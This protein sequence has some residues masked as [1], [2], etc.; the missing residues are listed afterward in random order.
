MQLNI[1]QRKLVQSEPNG[2][3]LIKGVAGS[4]KTTV[5]VFRIP[6]L[7]SHYCYEPDDKILLVTYNKT[8]TNYISHVFNKMDDSSKYEY[9]SIFGMD[10][11]KVEIT[12]IDKIVFEYFLEYKKKNRINLKIERETRLLYQY[13]QQCIAEVKKQYPDVSLIEQKYSSFLMDEIAWIKACDYTELEEYMD[14]D[15]LG[16]MSSTQGD[17]PQRIQKRSKTR[18]AIFELMLRYNDLLRRE[19]KID[20]MDMSCFALKQARQNIK[21]KYTHIIIDESQDLTKIQLEFLTRLYNKKDYSSLMFICDTAQTIYSQSWLVKGRTYSSIGFDM[22]G[23]SQSLS[24]N[25]R[26]TTQVAQAAYSLIEND[27]GFFEDE[28]FVKPS[29]IDRQGEYP[30]YRCFYSSDAELE[31][32]GK[33]I[34]NKLKKE[35]RYQDIVLIARTKN[36]LQE[37][38][39]RLSSMDIP[40]EMMGKDI[41]FEKD[42][43]K[44]LTMHSV[45]GLEFK[46][47]FIFGL[48]R[49]VIPIQSYADEDQALQDIT[50]KK[51]LYVGMTRAND[52]LYLSSNG[53]ESRF[54]AEINPEYLKISHDSKFGRFY[55]I[56]P[57][58]YRFKGLIANL[59]SNEEKVRQWFINELVKNYKYPEKLIC[60][61]Y[62]VKQFSK[63]GS[64]DIAVLIYKDQKPEPFIFAEIK[65]FRKGIDEAEKQ[66][67]CYMASTLTCQYGVATDGNEII[68]IDRNGNQVPDIP[69]FDATMLPSTSEQYTFINLSNHTYNHFTRDRTIDNEINIQTECGLRGCSGDDLMSIPVY[70]KIAA[71]PPN[72]IVDDIQSYFCLPKE[73]LSSK[74]PYFMARVSG[75]SMKDANIHDGDYILLK[76]QDYAENRD[77]VAVSIGDEATLKRYTK[78]GG[79]VLLIPENSDYEPI[80]VNSEEARIMGVA[81]GIIKKQK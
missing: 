75:Q 51:L 9:Q 24:K 3:M 14:V 31:W 68:I 28:N 53:V 12:N 7:L 18:R 70:N 20:F 71:S 73:W 15:R 44:L 26:T 79:T 38:F 27:P 10:E 8:L 30:V 65:Q 48:N 4:G 74:Q 55:P 76:K 42:V 52:L 49:D 6:F 19:G 5:A 13:L 57:E 60:I 39:E 36:Q 69:A 45:K 61:E 37:A 77:I 2:H 34:R 67:E 63:T 62:K 25:Y 64:V 50:E 43:V 56:K 46:V 78:M 80:Q 40:V 81:V 21:K 29:L 33:T 22:T 17:G 54:I 23:K 41:N 1:E 59:Y 16:R 32:I 47:V 58:Q 35:Y 11:S 66:L 72:S